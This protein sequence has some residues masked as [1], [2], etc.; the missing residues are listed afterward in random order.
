MAQSQ[1][2]RSAQNS[3]DGGRVT[4]VEL[5][6]DR[7][8]W[9]V[10][11]MTGEP[12]V[13]HI[14]VDAATGALLGSTADRMPDHARKRLNIPLGL[15][16]EATIDRDQAASKALEKVGKGFVDALSIQGR[17][18]SPRWE[19]GVRDSRTLHEI[20]ID[21]R[22]GRVVESRTHEAPAVDP[23]SAPRESA[24][25]SSGT[26]ERTEQTQDGRD[27]VRERSHD[28]GR[29]HYDWGQHVPR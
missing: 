12:R 7:K 27:R 19:V 13:H 28:Y 2:A 24:T 15:L 11:V 20:G 16:D 21:A 10:D 26:P 29:D 14:T 8:A 5:K 6:S 4:S 1:A 17:P 3:V 23:S 22:S 18:D 25:Q 9:K